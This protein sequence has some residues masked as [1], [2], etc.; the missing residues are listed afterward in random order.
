MRLSLPEAV[1]KY[2][3][4]VN[5]VWEDEV[6]WC[7]KVFTPK[8]LKWVNSITRQVVEH[9]YCNRDIASALQQALQNVVDRCLIDELKTFDGCFMIRDVRGLP[10]QTS[11]HSYAC[12]IDIN[13]AE[14][15]LGEKPKLSDALVKC[16][17]DAG[18]SWGGSF[19]RV[20]GM[21]FSLAWEWV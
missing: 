3:P 5:G 17:T 18:F 7:I 2:G 19:H 20:D 13:A 8:E 1:Q 14:N 11:T 21:H 16:F 15:R 4:I 9:I 6:K 10:G 12:A